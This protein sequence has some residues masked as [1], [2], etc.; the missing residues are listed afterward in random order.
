MGVLR[1][2]CTQSVK[3]DKPL[4]SDLLLKTVQEVI[5]AWTERAFLLK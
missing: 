2:S 3:L 1:F 5:G 4:K